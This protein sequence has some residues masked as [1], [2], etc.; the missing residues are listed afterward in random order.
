MIVSMWTRPD[1]ADN[2]L[3]M[4]PKTAREALEAFVRRQDAATLASVLLGLAEDQ[5]AVR[6]RLTR[7]QLSSQPEA[8]AT[9]F[10]KTLTAWRRSDK[11][12]GYPQACEFGRELE[13]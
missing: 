9:E 7:L 2:V 6:D 8:L 4:H 11:Y 12:L 5:V 1:R 10:R 13:A 3:P